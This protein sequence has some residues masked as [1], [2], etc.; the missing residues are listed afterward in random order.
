MKSADQTDM[1]IAILRP[2]LCLGV[3]CCHFGSSATPFAWHF[4]LPCCAPLFFLISFYLFAE[5]FTKVDGQMVRRR[6]FRLFLP[7]LSW[8]LIYYLA[9]NLSHLV[10]KTEEVICLKDFFVQCITG[11]SYNEP[12]WFQF[13]LIVVT[14][15]FFII[16]VACQDNKRVVC[17]VF[18][19][20]TVLALCLQYTSLNFRMFSPLDY[21]LRYPL[22]RICEMLPYAFAGMVLPLAVKMEK[23]KR[24]LLVGLLLSGS[25][26]LYF[27]HDAPLGFGYQGIRILLISISVFL[28]FKLISFGRMPERMKKVILTLSKYT[29]GI[30][31]A[32]LLIERGIHH[33][34]THLSWGRL[35]GS[36]LYCVVVY[37]C[38]YLLFLS[39]DRLIGN[40]YLNMVFQ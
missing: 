37:G 2:L 9:I 17:W 14:L 15:L 21:S 38:G 23:W 6:L 16:S 1:G 19:V 5:R 28:A 7:L 33:L 24:V 27:F 31:C 20:L 35:Y 18:G 12:M 8:A 25:V 40:K 39:M 4:V 22:G 36:F 29:L 13:V 32:H 10:F 11:H 3:V 26:L 30:Y 34:L